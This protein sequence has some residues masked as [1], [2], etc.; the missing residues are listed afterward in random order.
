[1]KPVIPIIKL[2]LFKDKD[3]GAKFINVYNDGI[4]FVIK[5]V[6][7]DAI[8][9]KNKTKTVTSILSRLP[10]ISVGLVNILSKLSVFNF[11]GVCTYYYK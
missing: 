5:F 3:E 8:I 6:D 2:E 4:K 10:I 1:M 9:I 11:K 7:I